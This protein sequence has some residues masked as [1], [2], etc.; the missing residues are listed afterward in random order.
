[1]SSSAIFFCVKG[2]VVEIC[3]AGPVGWVS[4]RCFLSIGSCV[5]SFCEC[6]VRYRGVWCSNFC[7][8]EVLVG[9]GLFVGPLGCW[10]FWGV[11]YACLFV[12]LQFRFVCVVSCLDS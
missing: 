5:G 11:F 9:G 10:K 12:F 1:M 2:M 3:V 6:L 4:L 7:R 8:F